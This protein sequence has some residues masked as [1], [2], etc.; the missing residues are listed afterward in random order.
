MVREPDGES[1]FLAVCR[2][3]CCFATGRRE[4]FLFGEIPVAIFVHLRE[5]FLSALGILLGAFAGHPLLLA[6]HTVPVGVKPGEHRFALSVRRVL[7][8]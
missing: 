2:T 6:D 8:Q 4:K 7:R 5:F 1:L 3:A